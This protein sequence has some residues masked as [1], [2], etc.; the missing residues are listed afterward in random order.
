MSNP[1]S[2]IVSDQTDFDDFDTEIQC[3]EVYGE[4]LPDFDGLDFEPFEADGGLTGE[5]QQYLGEID[6][7]G[8]F[9]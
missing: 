7:E 1:N 5:A 9:V 2:T 3:E 8:G 4:E 6:R